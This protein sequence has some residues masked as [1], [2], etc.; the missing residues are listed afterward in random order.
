MKSFIVWFL[1]IGLI[2]LFWVLV[3]EYFTELRFLLLDGGVTICA[4]TLFLY[5]YSGLFREHEEFS[6]GMPAT[7]VHLT[8][9]WLY[10]TLAI[11]G[12]IIGYGYSISFSWQMLYQLACLFLMIIGFFV[13]NASTERLDVV[14]EANQQRHQAKDQMVALSQQLRIANSINSSVDAALKGSINKLC[15]RIGYITPS[16]SPTAKVLEDSLR[17]SINQLIE[18]LNSGIDATSL[19]GELKKAQNILSQRIKTY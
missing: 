13:G 14:E 15:E 2:V 17:K 18:M 1:G 5:V 3:A 4:Y 7:G 19:E 9:L 10:V 16:T 12:I 6:R 8:A 11:G